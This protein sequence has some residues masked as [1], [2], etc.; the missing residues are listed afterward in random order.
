MN[1]CLL[2]ALQKEAAVIQANLEHVENV[3]RQLEKSSGPQLDY[4]DQMTD[5]GLATVSSV[6]D[7]T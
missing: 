6:G 2:Y 4:S 1:S 3:L 7:L 5:C